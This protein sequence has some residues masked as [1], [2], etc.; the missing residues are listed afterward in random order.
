MKYAIQLILMVLTLSVLSACGQPASTEVSPITVL[1]YH[2]FH[3]DAAQES[4]VT[5]QPER[6]RDQLETLKEAGYTSI[7]ERD[8]YEHLYNGKELPEKPLVITIDDG[9]ESNYEYAYPILEELEMYATIYVVTSYRGETPGV[10]PHFDWGQAREMV[11]SGW[12]DIQNHTHDGH[13]YVETTQDEGPFMTNK[14][15]VDG[16]EETEEEYRE[17]IYQDLKQA[18]ELIETEIGNEVYSFTYPFGAFNETVIDVSTELGHSIMYTV[19]E[20]VNTSDTN[21]YE[22]NRINADGSYSGE[23]LLKVIEKYH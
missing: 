11:E 2:H 1:M 17:R 23:D 14:M 13:Y 3:E 4:S 20:G 7:S 16:T 18:K 22:L 8:L 5:M 9:Y 10:S 15:L 12:I 6:F 21:P 19:R